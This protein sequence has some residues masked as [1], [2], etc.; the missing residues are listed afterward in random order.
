MLVYYFIQVA[1][2]MNVYIY[3]RATFS[4][5]MCD[6]RIFD[7]MTLRPSTVVVIVVVA[8]RAAT[9]Q[10]LKVSRP[11]VVYCIHSFLLRLMP[12][13]KICV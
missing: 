4:Y 8:C 6:G 10:A 13:T 1:Y 12:A 7:L 2:N 9:V 5:F 3:S 11:I